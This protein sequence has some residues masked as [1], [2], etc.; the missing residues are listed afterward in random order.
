MIPVL[1]YIVLKVFIAIDWETFANVVHFSMCLS[2][3][4]LCNRI[5]KLFTVH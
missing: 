1:I 2:K 3:R 5:F 4:Q